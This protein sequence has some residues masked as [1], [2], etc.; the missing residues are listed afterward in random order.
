MYM[1][2][3]IH[4]Y[5]CTHMHTNVQ[6]IYVHAVSSVDVTFL[7]GYMVYMP[8]CSLPPAGIP[9]ALHT[10]VSLRGACHPS[11]TGHSQWTVP[12]MPG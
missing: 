3:H 7:C 9:A 6:C 10:S 8:Q 11:H 1:Y 4:V 5:T 12:S 2:V